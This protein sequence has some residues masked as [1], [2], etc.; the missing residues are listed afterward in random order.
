MT[1]CRCSLKPQLPPTAAPLLSCCRHPHCCRDHRQAAAAAADAQALPQG[2]GLQGCCRAAAPAA[3][4]PLPA[5]RSMASRWVGFRTGAST[6]IA[7]PPGQANLCSCTPTPAPHA[8][9]STLLERA[10][11]RS[12]RLALPRTSSSKSS[13]SRTLNLRIASARRNR[14][15]DGRLGG[16]QLGRVRATHAAVRSVGAA[17]PAL[18]NTRVHGAHLAAACHHP[19]QRTHSQLGP[20]GPRAVA[21]WWAMSSSGAGPR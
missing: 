19:A 15:L 21:I 3:P 2:R 10:G 18:S 14:Y 17:V 6:P 11:N 16:R 9:K 13:S 5:Q 1:R 8:Q 4:K 12:K 20:L 7:A